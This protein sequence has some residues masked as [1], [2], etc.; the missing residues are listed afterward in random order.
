MATLP[1]FAYFEGKIA[2]Y[3]EAK[4]G[5]T[6]LWCEPIQ[7]S[8]KGLIAYENFCQENPSGEEFRWA[9]PRYSPDIDVV[10]PKIAET[11]F[12]RGYYP[13][14]SQKA[15]I[16]IVR[17]I[18]LS[19]NDISLLRWYG[20]LEEFGEF[21]YSSCKDNRPVVRAVVQRRYI[22]KLA[23]TYQLVDQQQMVF[24]KSS[25]KLSARAPPCHLSTHKQ[26]SQHVF[27]SKLLHLCY[28]YTL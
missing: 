21:I 17:R 16:D 6:L 24:L 9:W 27:L 10:L 14:N 8:F 28:Y 2:P 15:G 18:E 1:K 7:R 5:L 4:I 26:N 12:I 19:P 20:L 25:L 3:S 13:S 23:S 22:S 11:H